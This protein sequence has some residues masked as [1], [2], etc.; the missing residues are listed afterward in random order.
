MIVEGL[1]TAGLW[2]LDAILDVLD[3]LP[4]FP[5]GPAT[6]I[7]SYLDLVFDNVTILPFFFPVS[8]AAPI[9]AIVFLMA[10]WKRIYHFILWVWHKVP[11]SSD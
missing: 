8:F 4:S 1:M 9:L 2:I 10:N 7:A 3:V 6:A 5:E 11:I